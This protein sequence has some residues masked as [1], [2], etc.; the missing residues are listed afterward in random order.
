MKVNWV[1][2]IVFIFLA[3]QVNILAE[4][5]VSSPDKSLS[6]KTDKGLFLISLNVEESAL[7]VGA[8]EFD[9]EIRNLEKSSVEGAV[10]SVTPWMPSMGHG[11]GVVPGIT[12]RSNGIYR[13]SNVVF[14]MVGDWQLKV[15]VK[16]G[17]TVD[18]AVF[19]VHPVSP[20]HALVI[21]KK[22]TV[23]LLDLNKNQWNS[24]R[25]AIKKTIKVIEKTNFKKLYQKMIEEK[26]T[27]KSNLFCKTIF[28]DKISIVW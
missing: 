23:S 16:D 6:Q 26:P 27:K 5:L 25:I 15:D 14:S 4:G 19:D 18:T 11:S 1:H 22:H 3:I 8:N 28:F 24:L 13:A 20:G 2:K 7:Q 12:N 9:L 10:V 21:P 17:N